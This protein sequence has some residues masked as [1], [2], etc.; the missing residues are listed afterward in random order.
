MDFPLP[1]AVPQSMVSARMLATINQNLS[2]GQ[3]NAGIVDG[4]AFPPDDRDQPLVCST[5]SPT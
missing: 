2:I 1:F 4:S 5:Y 3:A